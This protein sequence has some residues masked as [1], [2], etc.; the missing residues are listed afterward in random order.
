MLTGEA[1]ELLASTAVNAESC[2][3]PATSSASTAELP[4]QKLC[5]PSKRTVAST[6]PQWQKRPHSDIRVR[7]AIVALSAI[8]P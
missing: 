2:L 6:S 4:R 7:P 3:R 1:I 8:A 5:V